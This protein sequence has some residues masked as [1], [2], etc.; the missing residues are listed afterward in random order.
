MLGYTLRRVAGMIP[1]IVAVATVTFFLMQSVEGGPFDSDRP[2]SEATRKNLE[3]RYGLDDPLPAQYLKY[4]FNLAKGDLGISLASDRD[5]TDIIRER[6]GVSVQV[7][8]CAFVFAALV[9]LLLGTLSALYQN[10]AA[11]YFGVFFATIGAALPTFVLAPILVIIF[12]LEAGWTDVL[13]WEFGNLRKMVLP[14]V[15]LGLLGGAFIARITRAAM[16]EVLRQDYIRTARAKGLRDQLIVMRHAARN[17]LIPVLTVM[18]PIF[19]DLIT[20]SFIIEQQFAIPGLGEAFV[21]AVLIR[22]YGVIM[23]VAVFFTVVIAFMNLLV[24]LA[25]RLADPRIRY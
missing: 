16:V 9:G 7:G 5:V 6:M 21:R 3:Q 22:D 2:L 25:Y 18:G 14:T 17:A 20:G 12:S 15:A 8:A 23:G 24:D 1:L 13:G 19:A 11:D 10:G 4:L